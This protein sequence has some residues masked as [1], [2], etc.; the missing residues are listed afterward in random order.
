ML[1]GALAPTEGTAYISGKDIRTD[2][3]QIRGNIGIC[4]QH[5]CLFRKLKKTYHSA[6]KFQILN[7]RAC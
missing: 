1:T 3:A 2:M 7:G 6:D 4:L 5:D